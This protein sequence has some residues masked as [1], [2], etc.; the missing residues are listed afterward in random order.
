M[1]SLVICIQLKPADINSLEI[2]KL[3]RKIRENLF[4][5]PI[6]SRSILSDLEKCIRGSGTISSDNISEISLSRE[7]ISLIEQVLRTEDTAQTTLLVMPSSEG[8]F[9][10]QFSEQ[11]F[12][13]GSIFLSLFLY[14]FFGRI[15]NL[16]W[17]Q[18]ICTG[19]YRLH[20]QFV[21]IHAQY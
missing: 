19:P 18:P 8:L 3:C 4:D 16:V 12:C 6:S 7:M 20:G 10:D 11:L 2:E 15:R 21:S 5:I 9:G 1:V 17:V 14:Y 13:D